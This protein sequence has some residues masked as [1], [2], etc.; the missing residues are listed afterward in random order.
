MNEREATLTPEMLAE[1]RN[2]FSA[3][4]HGK[5]MQNAV[6]NSDVDQVA[7]NHQV[8]AFADRSMSHKLDAWPVANQKKSGRCWLFAGLNLLRSSMIK[9][10]NVENFEFS[11]TYLFYWD[12]LEKANYFLESQIELADRDL[13]DR[14]VSH[15]LSDPIGDGGQWNM[16]VA[17]VDKYGVVPKW[18]MPETES[19][20]NSKNM[21]RI[22]ERY[23]REGALAVRKAAHNQ[24]ETV[25]EV[26][27]GLLKGVHRI[28][29]IHLGTPPEKFVWQYNDKDNKFERLGEVTPQEFADKYI[30]NDLRNYVCLVNDPR[31]AN[32]Y[33]K[34][35]TVDRLGNVLGAAP[36]R[37]LNVP[38]QVMKDCAA[39]VLQAGKPVW[40]GCDTEQQADRELSLWDK[41]LYDYGSVYGVHF[42]MDK[43]ERL[44]SHESLMTHA[45]LFVGVDM[46]DGAPRRWRVENSWGCEDRADQGFYTMNDSWFDEYVFEIAVH[47][48]RLPEE[49]RAVLDSEDAPIV[50]PAWD[51]MGSLA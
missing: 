48:D 2:E 7:Q 28:L 19:S 41:N 18:A 22:L 8:V 10:L 51:P 15:L 4:P 26:K 5:L 34:T 16:F 46:L 23:L 50:L 21:D 24:P 3:D 38:I 31:E 44:L 32:P 49:Y 47:R 45:M 40:F 1:M 27:A 35:Y 36:V 20:S 30:V 17:L 11:Q 33:G 6:T 37:Y 25:E 29:N 42:G 43:E 9:R 39:T 13:D 12:K 14:T